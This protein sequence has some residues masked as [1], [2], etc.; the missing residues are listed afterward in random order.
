[1]I[2]K[3]EQKNI[4]DNQYMTL[5]KSGLQGQDLRDV[6]FRESEKKKQQK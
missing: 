2:D 6:Q 4:N 1:M 3:D 5:F